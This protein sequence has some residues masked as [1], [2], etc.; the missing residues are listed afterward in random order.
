MSINSLEDFVGLFEAMGDVTRIRIINLLIQNEVCVKD[1]CK[2]IQVPQPRISKHLN[3]LKNKD[4]VKSTRKGP[5]IYYK[6]VIGDF[7]QTLIHCLE[8]ARKKFS[9][10]RS[11]LKRLESI[12]NSEQS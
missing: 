10:L 7:Q 4:F 5:F 12:R 2:A 6:L 8:N 3:I 9:I 1:L 11:D